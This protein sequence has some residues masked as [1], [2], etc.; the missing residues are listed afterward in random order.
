MTCEEVKPYIVGALETLHSIF[1]RDDWLSET[2]RANTL[3]FFL[4]QCARTYPD[5]PESEIKNFSTHHDFRPAERWMDNALKLMNVI[6][7]LQERTRPGSNDPS[8]RRTVRDL[9]DQLLCDVPDKWPG[10][11]PDVADGVKRSLVDH[12]KW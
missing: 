9:T 2:K 4:Y 5:A 7:S 1:C 3:S 12:A 11:V 8:I 10:K 6:E